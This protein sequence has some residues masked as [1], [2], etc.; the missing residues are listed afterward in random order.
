MSMHLDVVDEVL[1]GNLEKFADLVEPLSDSVKVGY[2][3]NPEEQQKKADSDFALILF[4]PHVGTLN[5]FAKYTP[6][7]TELNLA[8]L[9]DKCNEL[10]DE[11]VKIAS[12]NLAA[13]AKLSNIEVPENLQ[14]YIETPKY[15]EN[16]LDVRG[17]DEASFIHKTAST[18]EVEDYAWPEEKRYPLGN[19][20]NIE[21]AA[22]Y[23]S[24]YHSEMEVKQ[25]LEY[26]VNTKL[27][28][29]RAD[30]DIEM[31]E[32][33]KYAKLS[34]DIFNPEFYDHVKI[35]Q[36]YLEDNEDRFLDLYTDVL[37]KADELGPV[38]TAEVLY[39]I[40][41]QADLSRNYGVG[42]EDPI[43][44][45]LHVPQDAERVIDGTLVKKSSLENLDNTDLTELVGNDV[46]AELK[47]EDGLD[48]LNSLPKP[49]RDQI[50]TQIG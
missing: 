25:K 33:D 20:Q 1:G 28:A 10:P 42:I 17:I 13:A 48:V 3:P 2:I 41:K 35:R 45:T 21:K 5:K 49:I 4:H 43:L 6:E 8:Y 37:K 38:K 46:I 24:I 29:N 19:A 27:A 30:L 12:T 32:I 14:V 36:S 15:I 39:E 9:S 47:G 16:T 44:S 23:F 40:D 22:D 18:I 34:R 50:L 11:V 31:S 7:L 26:A